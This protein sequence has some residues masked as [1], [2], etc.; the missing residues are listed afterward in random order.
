MLKTVSEELEKD[1]CQWTLTEE[2]CPL[3]IHKSAYLFY[4]F[5]KVFLALCLENIFTY[6]LGKGDITLHWG[7]NE[8]SGM[9]VSQPV[10]CKFFIFG[11][12]YFWLYKSFVC[13]KFL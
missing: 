12:S 10:L 8:N 1:H 9:Q 7:N 13:C 3:Q 11:V 2:L 4:L 6:P 5:L